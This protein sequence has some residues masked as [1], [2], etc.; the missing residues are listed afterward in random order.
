MLVNNEAGATTIETTDVK[1]SFL[2]IGNALSKTK[3]CLS[4]YNESYISK[5]LFTAREFLSE[6]KISSRE[7]PDLIILDIP[8]NSKDIAEFTSWIKASFETRIP[9]IYNESYIPV[10]HLNEIK[11]LRQIDDVVKIE[12]YCTR[13]HEKAK[14]LKKANA[15]LTKPVVHEKFHKELDTFKLSN[16]KTHI[17]KRIF[18]IAVSL[19]AILFFLPLFIIIA[20]AIRIESRGPIFYSASRAGRGFK[21]FKFYKFRTMIPDAD[22]KLSEL[23]GQNQYETTENAPSFFKLKNDPRITKIG[24]FLRNTSLDELPQ[25]F[26]VLKG[27]MSIVGNR[28]L[29]LY[30]GI[31]LTTNEWS[32]RFMAP[33]GITGLWQVSKRGKE[34]MSVEE[35]MALDIDYARNHSLRVDLMIMLKTPTALFQK[36]NV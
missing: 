30:E 22:K 34:E 9:V 17:G 33:A 13:L 12:S 3:K 24:T 31:T 16:A 2:Y 11:S 35:R 28:P 25:L 23:A 5:N 36:S 4:L 32:E 29:P 18:D 15:Y 14:F 19:I 7:L 6:G 21:I 26:N 1:K 8:Y 20:I 27:D 10:Q